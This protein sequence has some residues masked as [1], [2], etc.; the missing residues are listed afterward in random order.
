MYQ[1]P[2]AKYTRFCL[3]IFHGLDDLTIG[4]ESAN[5]QEVSEAYANIRGELSRI[6]DNGQRMGLDCSEE[7]ERIKVKLESVQKMEHASDLIDEALQSFLRGF[8]V[9]LALS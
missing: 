9:A 3:E 7:I 5:P 8:K 4:L 1:F 2:A 6:I